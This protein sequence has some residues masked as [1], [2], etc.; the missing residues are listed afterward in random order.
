M[1]DDVLFTPFRVGDVLAPNRVLMAPMTRSRAIEGRVPSPL[2][3]R[4][5]AQRASAGLI[6]TEATHVSPDGV[7]YP[8][9][10]G[11]HTPAQIEGWR[12]VTDAVHAAGGRIYVQLWHVGRIS[13]PLWQPDGALPVAPSAIAPAG[14][15]WTPEG[16]KPFV[17]PRALALD[18]LPGIVAAFREGARCAKEA[19]FDGAELHGANGYLLDQFLR[20]GTNKRTDAYGG[21]AENRAR[22]MVEVAAAVAEVF[23]PERVGVRLSP[24]G[25]FN[26]MADSDPRHTFTTAARLLAPLDL[27][28]LHLVERV[29]TEDPVAPAI[30]EIFS[31]ALIVNGGYDAET[32]RAAIASGVADAVAFGVPFL[33]NPDLPTR[34]RLGE[35]LNTPDRGTFYTP[36]AKGYTDYPALDL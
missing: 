23:G 30:R 2:A 4:Y 31:G 12:A 1:S 19:G 24:W 7:G 6:F 15:A 14:E 32:A 11:V 34:Y 18:E 26:D 5:Y 20:D 28:F 9:T 16:M 25:N 27:A 8:N 3:A 13:H 10:P 22:L 35:S 36:G 33:A 17:T 21:P 29:E